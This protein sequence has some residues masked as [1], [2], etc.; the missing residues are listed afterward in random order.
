MLPSI[1]SHHPYAAGYAVCAFVCLAAQTMPKPRA[2]DSPFYL[3]MFQLLHA[4][5]LSIP[6]LIAVTFPPQ[7]ARLFNSTMQPEDPQEL[8][9]KPAQD[10]EHKS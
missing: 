2:N 6:R 1:V 8:E 4:I 10:P 3:W 5:T 7:Y 9:P